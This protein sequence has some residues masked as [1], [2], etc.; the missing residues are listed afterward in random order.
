LSVIQH[1]ATARSTQRRVQ[2]PEELAFDDVKIDLA[3][4]RVYRG[5][6]EVVLTPTAFRLLRSLLE[7]PTRVFTR[8]RILAQV[9]PHSADIDLRT[10]DVHIARLR[11]ALTAAGEPDLIR[12]VRTIGYALDRSVT[13]PHG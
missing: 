3:T 9:W 13:R 8:D 7:T 1:A 10:I 6:R 2:V 11:K 12:T 5:R 4:Y